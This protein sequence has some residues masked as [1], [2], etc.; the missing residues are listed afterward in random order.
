MMSIVAPDFNYFI[1]FRLYFHQ[2]PHLIAFYHFLRFITLH[3]ILF[4]TILICFNFLLV[5]IFFL[6]SYYLSYFYYNFK[7]R[8]VGFLLNNHKSLL[9]EL[10]YFRRKASHPIQFNFLQ[11][12]FLANFQVSLLILNFL[13]L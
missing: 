11:Y 2:E 1:S 5:L 3:F 6:L 13:L 8:I 12:L 9:K 4:L 7:V 10:L